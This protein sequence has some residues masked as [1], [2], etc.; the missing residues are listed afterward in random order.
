MEN[1]AGR[2]RKM[3]T[4]VHAEQAGGSGPYATTVVVAGA[5]VT[6]QKRARA[7]LEVSDMNNSRVFGPMHHCRRPGE[8]PGG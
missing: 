1:P 5:W 2:R 4:D 6:P 3:R 8:D 7:T